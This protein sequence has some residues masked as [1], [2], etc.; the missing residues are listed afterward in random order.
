MTIDWKKLLPAGAAVALFIALTLAYFSP[1]M[2]GKRLIQGDIRNHAGMAQDIVEHR[3][4]Y[5]EEPLWAGS[6]FSGM[7]AYQIS[8]IWSGS[9]IG[10]AHV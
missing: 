9:E 4:A 2:E 8:V 7:P 10:R 6:M 1:V 5:G 3:A